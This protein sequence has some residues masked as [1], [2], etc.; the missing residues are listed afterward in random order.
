MPLAIDSRPYR[1]SPACRLFRIAFAKHK[2][3]ANFMCS[4]VLHAASS[5]AGLATTI[6]KPRAQEIR[7]R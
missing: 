6:A 5:N 4:I 1:P 7:Y 2:V 3:F